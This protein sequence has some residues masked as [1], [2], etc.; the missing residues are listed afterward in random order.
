MTQ[1]Y[2]WH[3]PFVAAFLFFVL[4]FVLVSWRRG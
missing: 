1:L 3:V 4:V 2:Q